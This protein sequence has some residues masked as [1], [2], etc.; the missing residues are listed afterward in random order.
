MKIPIV[1]IALEVCASVILAKKVPNLTNYQESWSAVYWILALLSISLHTLCKNRNVR[2]L[3]NSRELWRQKPTYLIRRSLISRT[4]NLLSHN[5][6]R[7]S[8]QNAK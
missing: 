1:F 3:L 6:H 5:C 7:T 4:Q 8:V 2:N